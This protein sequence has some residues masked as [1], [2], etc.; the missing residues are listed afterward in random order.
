MAPN[1][2]RVRPIVELHDLTKSFGAT[3]AVRDVSFAIRPQ[4]VVGLVGENGAGKSTL[5]RILA[6]VLRPDDGQLVVNGREVAFGSPHQAL[7]SGIAMM[8]QE[9]LL[10]P[11]RTVEDNVLLSDLP[12]RGPFPARPRMRARYRQ[13]VELSGFDLDPRARVRDLRLADQQ[14][15]EIMRA[16]S[17][18]AQ[19]V[20]MDEP[21]A[22][23]AADEVARLH[24]SI[25]SI[26]ERGSSILLISHLLEEVLEITTEVAIMRDGK[27]IRFGPTEDE[28][29]NTLVSG[30]VGR[31]IATEYSTPTARSAE[32]PPLMEVR[33]L[34]REGVLSD[35]S[36]DL[37]AGEIVGLAGLVGSGRSEIARCLFGAD[38]FDRG[39][40]VVGGES[41]APRH[42]RDAIEAGVFM[43]PESRKDQG[44]LLEAS[45]R[46]NILLSKLSPRARWS[47]LAGAWG[48]SAGVVAEQVDLRYQSLKQPV[49]TLSGGN[50]QKVLLGRA[51]DA[52]P[53]ILIA[54]E[55]TRGVDIAAKRAIH[56]VLESWADDGVGVLFISSELEEVL[57]VCSRV[58]VVHRGRLVE[59]FRPPYDHGS[60][61]NAFFGNPGGK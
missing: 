25:R 30:M 52:A 59:E 29:V 8:T 39:T 9:I 35:I 46:D 47:V 27:L 56:S 55:P 31:A 15:V 10:V 20:V 4:T 7:R 58:L 2:A 16:L 23:L 34:S 54:D 37:R 19:L 22:A 3:K 14:K 36:F 12:R 26:T 48:K 45:V 49:G 38:P 53:R 57:G 42:P 43:V 21:S 61:L 1:V 11:D 13:L 60:V 18:D 50:Q 51:L 41:Y 44:L 24:D 40:I 28:T 32:G 33:G 5:A 6:G 17:T